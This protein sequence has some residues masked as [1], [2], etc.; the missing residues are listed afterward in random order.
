MPDGEDDAPLCELWDECLH[1]AQL[2]CG[3]DHLDFV[4]IVRAVT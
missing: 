3:R 2:W 1:L 4:E